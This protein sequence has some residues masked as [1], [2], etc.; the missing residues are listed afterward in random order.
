M[1]F[2]LK[3]PL[4]KTTGKPHYTIFLFSEF[5]CFMCTKYIVSLTIQILSLSNKFSDSRSIQIHKGS[6]HKMQCILWT[7]YNLQASAYSVSTWK[8][9][10]TL[11]SCSNK[12]MDGLSIKNDICIHINETFLSCLPYRGSRQSPHAL[13]SEFYQALVNALCTCI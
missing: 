6:L 9:L 12:C 3:G 11:N 2:V 4:F 1:N 10:M 13:H 8:D 7:K 5:V